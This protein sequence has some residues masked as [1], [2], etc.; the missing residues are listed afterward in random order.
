MLYNSDCLS[1][2]ITGIGQPLYQDRSTLN[3]DNLSIARI[4]TTVQLHRPLPKRLAV[5][6]PDGKEHM[7][8]VSYDWIPPTCTLCQEVG[9]NEHHCPKYPPTRP[10]RKSTAPAKTAQAPPIQHIFTDKEAPSIEPENTPT[11]NEQIQSSE[12]S[13]CMETHQNTV[14][15]PIM[16]SST[17]DL[18]PSTQPTLVP[19]DQGQVASAEVAEIEKD[20]IALQT[21]QPQPS[22][23]YSGGDSGGNNKGTCNKRPNNPGQGRQ[24]RNTST[25][26]SSKQKGKGRGRK[27][28][29]GN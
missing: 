20:R 1:R 22:S 4:Y 29:R 12:I 3:K 27:T 19:K 28:V 7:V 2:I 8:E 10:E 5:H 6:L 15:R 23:G 9:H 14:P 13:H 11:S 17:A 18:E 25:N 16:Q 24:Q 26:S 21:E